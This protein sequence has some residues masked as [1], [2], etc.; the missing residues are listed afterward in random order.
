MQKLRIGLIGAGRF[1]R[2]HVKVLQQIP[3]AEV[4]ALADI[5]SGALYS[6]AAECHLAPEACYSDPLELI[7]RSDLDAVDIVSD[8][9]SHGAL[10]LSAL[11]HGKHVI[12]EKP[13]SVS[14][15]EAQEIEQAAAAAG[16]QVMVG[17]ISRFSQ[18]Y[19]TIKRAIDS[20]QLGRIA[21]IRSKRDF[22]RSWFQGFGNRIH[23]VYESGVHELDLMLWYAGARC[24]KVSAFESS[25]SGYTYPDLFSAL[26]YFENGIMGS[27]NSSWMIPKGAPQNLVETLELD[28]TIDAHIEVVGEAATA[29]YQL[30]HQGLA[31]IT[32]TGMQYPETTLWPAGLTGIGELY[33]LSWSILCRAFR[34]TR[35]HR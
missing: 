19:F 14:F 15:A 1:G 34:G 5:N 30:A 4:A 16:K 7:R 13:L 10:V 24:V 3:G 26:L 18:P 29:Q 2:L 21:A 22:S 20:G 9:K 33:K 28:G 8:E 17:N 23:P 25:I 35:L 6:A 32:G 11:R 12:V 27:L 31:I